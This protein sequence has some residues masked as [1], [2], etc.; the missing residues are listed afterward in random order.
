MFENRK[1]E[2]ARKKK[3]IEILDEQIL[4][5]DELSPEDRVRLLTAR[6]MEK[7]NGLDV[8]D[9]LKVAA[10][11]AVL[12]VLVGVETHQILSQKGSRFIKVL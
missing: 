8:G 6:R 2:Q 1:N 10:N 4:N 11:V 12:L 3:V 5:D 7:N 9:I